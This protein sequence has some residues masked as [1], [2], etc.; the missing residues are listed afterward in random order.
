MM[1]MMIFVSYTRYTGKRKLFFCS[2]LQIQFTTKAS[3]II[4]ICVLESCSGLSHNYWKTWRQCS[5][6]CVKCDA[7]VWFLFG[8]FSFLCVY[9]LMMMMKVSN[10]FSFVLFFYRVLCGLLLCKIQ[11]FACRFHMVH[12][13]VVFCRVCDMWWCFERDSE[14][15]FV[16]RGFPLM[17]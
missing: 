10:E 8:L 13:F 7:F 2:F 17:W 6:Y 16:L 12:R 1:H 9:S 3:V 5:R 15:R 14:N 11:L 4:V